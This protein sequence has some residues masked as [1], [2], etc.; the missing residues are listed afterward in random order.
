[1]SIYNV[2]YTDQPVPAGV[3][4]DFAFVMPLN[5]VTKDEALKSAF[6][7]IYSG[8]VVWK[9]EGPNGFYLDREGVERE[10]R[11]FKSR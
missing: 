4:P 1:M 11:I 6:K 3:T 10:Y 8:A 2:F 5:F 9:I 7:L